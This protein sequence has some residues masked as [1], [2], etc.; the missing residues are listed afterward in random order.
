MS[1]GGRLP[2][3]ELL[4]K[5]RAYWLVRATGRGPRPRPD[6]RWEELVARVYRRSPFAALFRL[7]RLGLDLTQAVWRWEGAP[8]GLLSGVRAAALPEGSLILL[9]LGMGLAFAKQV[10]GELDPAAGEAVIGQALATFLALCGA[11]ARPGY[12]LASY[13]SLGAYVRLFQPRRT[14]AAGRLLAGLDAAAAECFWHGAGRG[15][16]FLPRHLPP[17]STAR[18]LA[19]C[20]REP[21]DA[22]ARADALGGFFVAATMVNLRHPAVLERVLA[23]AGEHTDEEEAIAGGIA[24]CALARRE[25]TPEDPALPALLAHRPQPRHAALWRQRVQEPVSRAL[26][27]YYPLLRRAGRLPELARHRDLAALARVCADHP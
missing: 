1:V 8:R 17:G 22:T 9:H 4:N 27:E 25:T 21:P 3:R 18:A 10:M 5:L 12:L 19:L 20:R 15:I 26:D 24:A 13:E 23:A 16:Y 2:G 7:E 14:A 6:D 11:N